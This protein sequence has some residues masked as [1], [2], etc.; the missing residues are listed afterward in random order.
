MCTKDL[1]SVLRFL[2]PK[3][4]LS[5]QVLNQTRCHFILVFFTLKCLE[6]SWKLAVRFLK[7]CLPEMLLLDFFL[8]NIFVGSPQG[9]LISSYSS[10]FSV[11]LEIFYF[12]RVEELNY[13]QNFYRTREKKSRRWRTDV[14]R[15]SQVTE[16]VTAKVVIIK[17]VKFLSKLALLCKDK[18]NLV[19]IIFYILWVHAIREKDLRP[20]QKR[21]ISSGFKDSLFPTKKNN[22][23][24]EVCT[25]RIRNNFLIWSTAQTWDNLVQE[26]LSSAEEHFN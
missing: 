10:H 17:I 5:R 21:L 23:F 9:K 14:L 26:I 1:N 19:M 25:R 16:N 3:N 2:R 20:M 7:H 15:H 11:M 4:Y 8:I 18:I 22:I 13:N 12:L 24:L 6:M